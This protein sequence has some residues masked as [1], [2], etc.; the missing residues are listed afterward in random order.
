MIRFDII[1]LFP[2][3]YTSPIET[4]IIKRAIEQNHISI[5]CTDLRNFGIG[6]YRQVDDTPYGGGHGM[7]LRPEPLFEAIQHVKKHN[8]GPVIFFTPQGKRWSQPKAERFAEKYEEII[9]ICGHYEGIDNRIREHCVDFEFSIGDYVLTGGELASLVFMD[10][11]IRLVPGVL[12]DDNSHQFDSFSKAFDRKKEY[13]VYTKPEEF[14]GW[15]VPEVL[16]SGNHKKIEAWKRE[17]L[18]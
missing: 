9:I 16:R 7:V 12:G 18:H 1:T 11:I 6:N 3:F 13:P 14:N 17:H 15:K 8:S 4:S 10:S 2:D 5:H